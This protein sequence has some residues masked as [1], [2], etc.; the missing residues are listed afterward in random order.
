M[1]VTSFENIPL[2]WI[3]C[4]HSLLFSIMFSFSFIFVFQFATSIMTLLQVQWYYF[5]SHIQPIEEPLRHSFSLLQ[6]FWFVALPFDYFV[7]TSPSLSAHITHVF[8]HIVHFSIRHV[9]ILI[10]YFKI[11]T[12]K[13]QN[14]FHFWF[15]PAS[16]LQT[17]SVLEMPCNY[18]L[19]A[20]NDILSGRNC[21]KWV[22]SGRFYTY[23]GRT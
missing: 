23:L 21:G 3:S 9:S 7:G 16:F 20:E 6:C 5:L 11:L 22:F 10:S 18:V 14:L 1:Y 19:K 15:W 17:V 4:S 12:W 13:F 8:L 2:S